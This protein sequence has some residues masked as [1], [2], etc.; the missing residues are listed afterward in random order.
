MKS[1]L[2][3]DIHSSMRKMIR[4]ETPFFMNP[5]CPP[6]NQLLDPSTRGDDST[7]VLP[8]LKQFDMK[9]LQQVDV[10]LRC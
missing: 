4:T 6:D 5:F 7:Y 3:K 8:T 2:R 1:T 9:L 10:D